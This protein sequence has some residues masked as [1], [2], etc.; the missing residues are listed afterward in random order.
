MGYDGGFTKIRM[1]IDTQKQLDRYNELRGK[2]YDIIGST[3]FYKFEGSAIDLPYLDNNWKQVEV[4]NKTLGDVNVRNNEVDDND[5]TLITEDDLAQYISDLYGESDSRI[6]AKDI[7]QLEHLYN[8]F[9][10][11][12]DTLVF[13]YSY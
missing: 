6:Y 13:Y 10:W 9:D 4:L 12:N 2:I 8:T 5:F 7:K 1:K 11:E 3:N